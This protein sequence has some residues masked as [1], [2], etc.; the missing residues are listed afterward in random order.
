M[1]TKPVIHLGKN[2]KLLILGL[3]VFLFVTPLITIFISCA[4]VSPVNSKRERPASFPVIEAVQPHWESFTTGI[5]YFHGRIARPNLEFWALRIELASPDTRIVV[6]GGMMDD[7]RTLS[8]R[9]SSFVRDNDLIAGVNAVPFDVISATEGRPIRNIGIVITDG[10]LIAPA[11]QRYDALVFY[12]DGTAAIVSQS[13]ID[14]TENIKNAIGGF[15]RVL[16]NGEPARRTLNLEPRHPRSAAGISTNGEYLYLLVIDGRRL[17]S[18]GA[19]EKEIALLLHALG[20]W[21]GL[22]FD[23]GGST[24]LVLRYP[25]GRAKPVNTPIHKGI[26]GRERAVAGCIGIEIGD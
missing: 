1:N 24:S 20:S 7:N 12:T 2:S 6:R 16:E 14:S 9:V 8:T 25:D 5:G 17:G 21:E 13:V 11:V 22:N 15:N 4:T 26:P 18:I 19:T 10:E 23:G 3:R